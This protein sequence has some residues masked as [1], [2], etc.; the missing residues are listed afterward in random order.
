LDIVGVI[1]NKLSASMPDQF[2]RI[3]RSVVQRIR[4]VGTKFDLNARWVRLWRAAAV[5]FA[6][7][8]AIFVAVPLI[9]YGQFRAADE[10]KQQILL[11]SAQEQGR[12]VV[13]SITPLLTRFDPATSKK[14]GELLGEISSGDTNIKVLLRPN[15]APNAEQFYYVASAPTV[16]AAYLAAEQKQLFDSG[17]FKRVPATCR[18]ADSAVARYTNPSGKEELLVSLNAINTKVGCWVVI[19]SSAAAD[20]LGTGI[21]RPYWKT[22]EIRLA[23]IIYLLMAVFVVLLFL[24][25]ARSLRRFTDLARRIRTRGSEASTF[26]ALNT[27]PELDT[28]AREFD[29]MVGSLRQSAELIR[30]TAEDNA[31]AF[32]TPIAVISQSLEPLKRAVENGDDRGARAVE[33]IENSVHR[34]DILVSAARQMDEAAAEIIDPSREAIDVAEL[35]RRMGDD[36]ADA[37]SDRE[38]EVSVDA[39]SSVVVLAQENSLETVLENIVENAASFSSPGDRIE[40]AAHR[41]GGMAVITVDD[42]GP[43]ASEPDLDRMFERYFS[44][45]E[46]QHSETEDHFGVGLW[47]VRRNIEAIGGT[48]AA[49]NRQ[50]GGLRMSITL[51]LA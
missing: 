50:E 10:E 43:G 30:F 26:A 20:F 36:Y 13:V 33:M 14:L 23:A 21:G 8:L 47:I 38:I 18:E 6:L 31:H 9:L 17:V 28:V 39:E 37:L 3:W 15:S 46:A 40:M 27:V 49:T 25:G 41:V 22:P 7:L 32:K 51:P 35:L 1:T 19:T 44:K 45:R 42:S 24:D 34:L 4:P 29:G 5:K 11:K 48:V 12:L 2:G 16:S